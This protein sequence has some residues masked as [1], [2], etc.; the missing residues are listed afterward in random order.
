MVRKWTKEEEQILKDHYPLLV[1]E[2]V[3]E[4]LPH[5]TLEAIYKKAQRLG[6]KAPEPTLEE[7]KK[8]AKKRY[9]KWRKTGKGL[10]TT[11]QVHKKYN[12]THSKQ[13]HLKRIEDRYGSIVGYETAVAH[14]K[15]K[16]GVVYCSTDEAII[17]NLL[18]DTGV[19]YTKNKKKLWF[20]KKNGFIPDFLINNQI[21]VEYFGYLRAR[22]VS[23]NVRFTKYE[24]KTKK[25]IA[26][27]KSNP[28][29]PF[30]ALYYEDLLDGSVVSKIR[31]KMKEV[32]NDV[33]PIVY[34]RQHTRAQIDQGPSISNNGAQESGELLEARMGNQQP[35]LTWDKGVRKV[36]RL[37]SELNN[38]LST[39][40]RHPDRMMI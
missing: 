16:D 17:A 4:L 12:K 3:H 23:S 28:Q 6:I 15:G 2:R 8:N 14:R 29:Y 19:P 35:S 31:A 22:R 37:E 1:S 5:Y 32:T 13:L 39:S 27:F 11:S 33:T 36:Q 10:K 25:K 9:D 21:Y 26:F 18:F 7:I 34:V 24:L 30:I 20:N 38:N 40:A